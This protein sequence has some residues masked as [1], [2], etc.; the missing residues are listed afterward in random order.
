M[1]RAHCVCKN[2]I[3]NCFQLLTGLVCNNIFMKLISASIRH[4]LEENLPTALTL[5]G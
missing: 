2:L 1:P 5:R 4:M 3:I